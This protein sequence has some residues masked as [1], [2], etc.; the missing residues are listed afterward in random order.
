MSEKLEEKA[1][2]LLNR[3]DDLAVQY[4]P[5]VIDAAIDVVRFN[6]LSNVV[7]GLIL[8][9]IASCLLFI[10]KRLAK[11]ARGLAEQ[12]EKADEARYG[13]MYAQRW[14]KPDFTG[15]YALW[16]FSGLAG[17]VGATFVFSTWSWVAIFHPKLALAK[18]VLGL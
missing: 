11:H 5:E 17:F 12:D 8:L 1:L 14:N 13:R 10:G 18:Q 2:E 7:S 9:A 15:A 16:L 4:T 3:F 6:G